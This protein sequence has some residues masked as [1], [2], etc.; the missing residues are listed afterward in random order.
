MHFLYRAAAPFT[1]DCREDIHK[2]MC[3]TYAPFLYFALYYALQHSKREKI[4]QA[5][6]QRFPTLSAHTYASGTVRS[7]LKILAVLV[8]VV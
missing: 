5:C 6:L 3:R 2:E 8:S 4:A 1:V 7:Q